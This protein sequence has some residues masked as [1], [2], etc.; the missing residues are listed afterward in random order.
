MQREGRLC[1]CA[2]APRFLAVSSQRVWAQNV[3]VPRLIYLSKLGN[4]H[5]HVQI[6]INTHTHTHTYTDIDTDIDTHIDTDTDTETDIDI[7]I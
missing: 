7:D 5:T 1:G 3:S 6:H 4:M 2:A